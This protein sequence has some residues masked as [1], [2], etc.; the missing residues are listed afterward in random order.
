MELS[1]R[2]VFCGQYRKISGM[3]TGYEG[4]LR[5][6]SHSKY[7]L[8]LTLRGKTF[9]SAYRLFNERYQRIE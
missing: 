5:V 9:Y 1:L 8:Y 2:K 3:H 6:R 4:V 7:G